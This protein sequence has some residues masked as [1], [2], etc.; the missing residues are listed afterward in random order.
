MK[1]QLKNNIENEKQKKK[2]IKIKKS[3][4]S[5]DVCD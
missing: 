1:K 4:L 5:V 2:E 3:T